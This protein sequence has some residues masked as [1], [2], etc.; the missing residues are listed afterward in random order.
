MSL[1]QSWADTNVYPIQKSAILDRKMPYSNPIL[2]LTMLLG[3]MIRLSLAKGD[4]IKIR[5]QTLE[6][7]VEASNGSYSIQS[8][9]S[10]HAFVARGNLKTNRGRAKIVDATDQEFGA[11]RS[12]EV[13]YPN[14][15]QDALQLFA[16]LP[17]ALLCRTL[18]NGGKDNL[19]VNSICPFG[20]R[21]SI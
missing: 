14:G 18:H 5:N 2:W 3:C 17:F 13:N 9:A 20:G 4:S 7:A 1:R 6:L 12:I 11:G 19:Q 16:D 8:L 15:D 21:R 10:G